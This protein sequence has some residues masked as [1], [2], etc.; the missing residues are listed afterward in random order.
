MV[1]AKTAICSQPTM[2]M[3]GHLC[4]CRAQ[5]GRCK[6]ERKRPRMRKR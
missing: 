4:P 5:A 2:L 1:A 6:I 3:C